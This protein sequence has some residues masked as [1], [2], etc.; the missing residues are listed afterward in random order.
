MRDIYPLVSVVTPVFNGEKY[1][2]CCINSVINQTYTNWEY[3]IVDNCSTDLTLSIAKKFAIVDSRIRVICNEI[4]VGVIENHNIALKL[5]S[6]DSAFCKVVSADDFIY[7]ICIQ[8]LV[9]TALQFE[10]VGIVGSYQLSGNEAGWVVKWTGLSFGTTVI[11]GRD[12][13]RTTLL[14]GK[15]VF[16]SPTSVI[17]RSDLV[18]TADNFY[19]NLTPQADVSAFYKYLADCDFGFVHQILSYE[20]IH[21]ESVG[22][23]CQ[24]ISTHQPSLLQDLIEYGPV[25]LS[26][27]ELKTRIKKIIYDY[28]AIIAEGVFHFQNKEFVDY[29]KK[30]LQEFGYSFFN[31]LLVRHMAFKIIDILFNPLKTIINVYKKLKSLF[32]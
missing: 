22:F 4:F 23:Q 30:R 15:Y 16:G 27:N 2:E 18:R 26:R 7:P 12:I 8:S 19:P 1:L 20:R 3:I 14:G 24:K 9:E 31:I 17:Y 13:C 11:S 32:R 29:H 25:Y 21:V 28:Y 10:S 5:I 6:A